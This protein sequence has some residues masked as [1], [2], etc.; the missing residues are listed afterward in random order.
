M[1][2]YRMPWWQTMLWL[3]VMA[4]VFSAVYALGQLIF[5]GH[6]TAW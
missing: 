1:T 4:V 6:V 2:P 3:L 5:Y